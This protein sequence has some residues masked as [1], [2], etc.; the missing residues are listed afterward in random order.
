MTIITTVIKN[1]NTGTGQAL[2]EAL[3]LDT[4]TQI[5]GTNG[6]RV[7]IYMVNI[8]N[9]DMWIACDVSAVFGFGLL[10]G[11]NGGNISLGADFVPLGP[12]NGIVSG[13]NNAIV[14]F[15]E[16]NR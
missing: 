6:L 13:N 3:I 4:S 15:Q 11:K 10:L 16:F 5:V 2:T 7:S 12:I 9:F 8:S 1:N 14:S